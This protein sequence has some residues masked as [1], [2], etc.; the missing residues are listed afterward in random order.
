MVYLDNAATTF[1]KPE[2]VYSFMDR[3][4]RECGVNVGRGQHR[5]A[6]KAGSLVK[7]TRL[8][9]L[10]MF[11]CPQKQVIFTPSATESLNLILQGVSWKD[12]YTVYI[13]PFE[14]NAVLRVLYHLQKMYSLSIE[15]LRVNKNNM[16][17]DVEGIKYQF[18]SKKPDVVIM[19][20]ASNVCG[21][22]AP[23]KEIFDLSKVY[24]AVNILDMAQTAGLIQTDLSIVNADYV[25]FAGHKTLYAPYGVAGIIFNKKAS[26]KPLL[27]GGTGIE[28]A[29]PDLP[30]T[31]PER[32]EV[33]S[34]NIQAISG[35]NAALQWIM[36]IGISKIHQ[37]ET[38]NLNQLLDVLRDFD[39]IE[40][41]GLANPHNHIGVV[42]CVFDGYSSDNIG[43]VLSNNGIAVRTGLHCAPNAHRFLGTFPD[44]TVRFS[45][46]YFNTNQDF[47]KLK[48]T[49]D[50]IAENS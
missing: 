25:V 20:H 37:R 10:E 1:P 27:Y 7:E 39:N 12:G 22:V 45:V 33:G 48:G 16:T 9:L 29:N 14:H 34:I 41:I 36:D 30:I 24:N 19:S 2:E 15:E 11:N 49:L 43:Q 50:F 13:T 35:L 26:L 38:E 8:L 32:Y 31:I 6:D 23:I 28:S 3:F 17:Y 44:G 40:I 42:S 5:L 18:Q 4:Y 46:G 21:L 47:I